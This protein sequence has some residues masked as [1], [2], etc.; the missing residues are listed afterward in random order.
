MANGKVNDEKIKM[1][2]ANL[3]MVPLFDSN[4]KIDIFLDEEGNTKETVDK[5]FSKYSINGVGTL[6]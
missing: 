2:L 4:D 6:S 5:D 1:F 3:G